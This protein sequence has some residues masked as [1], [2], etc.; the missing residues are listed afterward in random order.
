[1]D[2]ALQGKEG[3]D[4]LGCYE[5]TQQCNSTYIQHTTVSSHIGKESGLSGVL[6][7]PRCLPL[8]MFGTL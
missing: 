3:R 1:M 4:D 2:A 7:V 8:K 6:A 5:G